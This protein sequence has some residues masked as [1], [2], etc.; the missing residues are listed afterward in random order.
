MAMLCPRNTITNIFI[1]RL[2]KIFEKWTL[3]TRANGHCKR[4]ETQAMERRRAL[5][6]NSGIRTMFNAL[7]T[8][9]NLLILTQW[10]L[11]GIF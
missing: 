9:P 2:F 4:T 6:N 10:K 5:R 11:V 8:L 3:I 1:F 7:L